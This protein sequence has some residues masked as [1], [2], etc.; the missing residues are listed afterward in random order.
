M[1]D[2]LTTYAENTWCKGCGNFG[3][4]N[5]FKR[6]VRSL[7]E[8]GLNRSNL[9]ITAG[10]GCHGKIFDYLALSGLYSIHGRAMATAQGMKFANPE[11]KIVAFVGDGDAYGEGIAHLIFSAKRNA[12][13][14]VLVHNNGVYGLTTGQRT[15]TSEM[16]FKGR[17]TPRG[18]I[19]EPIKPLALMLEAGATFVGRGYPGK[20]SHLSELIVS[21]IEHSGFSYIDILQPCV[22]FNDTYKLYNEKVTII[23]ETPD[24]LED[25]IKLAKGKEDIPVGIFYQVEKPVY[26][27]KLYE[28]WNPIE[29]KLS[30]DERLK[31][32]E[33]LIS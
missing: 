26:H 27:K 24:N 21:S 7:E 17:S 23:D 8:N 13:I 33:R 32:V 5:A 3:I 1:A 14:T 12:D 9:L 15:P 11:H 4:F 30:R 18:S 16:G 19:E 20:L 29:K 10:I 25:A 22:T 31:T 6:A 28:D 2:D